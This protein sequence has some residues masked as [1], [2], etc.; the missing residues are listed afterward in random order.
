HRDVKPANVLFRTVEGS[1]GAQVVA[2][3]GDLGL[4]KAMDMSSRL[5]MVGGT[6]TYVAP[7]QALGEGLDARADQYSLAALT[8]YL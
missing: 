5:T 7:E 4:G 2:M 3:L 1:R 6:P 8:Y